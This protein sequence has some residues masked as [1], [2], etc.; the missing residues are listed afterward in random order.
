MSTI[1]LVA[2]S[3]GPPVSDAAYDPGTGSIRLSFPRLRYDLRWH[4]QQP[5][6]AAR[7]HRGEL[8]RDQLDLPVRRER[9]ARIELAEGAQREAREVV[10]EYHRERSTLMLKGDTCSGL[11]TFQ[12]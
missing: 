10:E 7:A 5:A 8:R 11:R 9:G 2:L 12:K 1:E 4:D 6:D 3:T